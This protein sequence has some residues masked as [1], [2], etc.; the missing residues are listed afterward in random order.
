MI[1]PN[2]SDLPRRYSRQRENQTTVVLRLA[3]DGDEPPKVRRGVKDPS[4]FSV[5][6]TPDVFS[7]RSRC[8]STA[9]S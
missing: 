3:R 4:C 8:L 1:R 7:I 6:V 9:H 2:D 5:L